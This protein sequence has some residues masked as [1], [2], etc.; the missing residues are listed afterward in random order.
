MNDNEHISKEDFI[1]FQHDMMNQSDK[2]K[3]LKHISCCNHCAD[4]FAV[5]ISEDLITAPRDMKANI[6]KA[7]RRPDVQL[8]IKARETSKRIQLLIYSLKVC[9]A[10]ACALLLLLFTMNFSNMNS[11]TLKTHISTDH[12]DRAPLTTMIKDGVDK[13]NNRMLDFSNNIMK[14]EVTNND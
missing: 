1:L 7:T 9:T 13:I 6:I 14:T 10:T 2:E 11:F 8:A 5:M 3:F 12:Q 4:Q